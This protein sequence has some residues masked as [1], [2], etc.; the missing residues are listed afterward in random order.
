MGLETGPNFPA[1]A[2]PSQDYID[3]TRRVIDESGI[4]EWVD[5]DPAILP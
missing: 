1:Q 3:H 4:M 5:W 2:Q